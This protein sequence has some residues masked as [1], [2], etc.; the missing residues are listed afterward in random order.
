[1]PNSSDHGEIYTRKIF[2]KLLKVIGVHPI[3]RSDQQLA[4]QRF[5]H[6]VKIKSFELPLN[7]LAQWI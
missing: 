1:M 3:M 2:E 6:A 5:N 7:L 4:S